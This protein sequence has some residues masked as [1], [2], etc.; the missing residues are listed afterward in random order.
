[1]ASDKKM[2]DGDFRRSSDRV[3]L[4]AMI[5]YRMGG[6]EYGN[7]AA[8]VSPHGIFL[9]TFMPP[10]VGTELDLVLE[11]PREQ[12][13]H[14]VVL[15]GKV[16]RVENGPDPRKNGMGVHFVSLSCTDL[17]TIHLLMQGLVALVD[18]EREPE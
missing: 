4:Q 12:G 1:M 7:L 11:I 6:Q 14:R 16:A 17:D 5:T 2:G 13:R 3:P 10:P 18:P 8:D 15:R 9:R